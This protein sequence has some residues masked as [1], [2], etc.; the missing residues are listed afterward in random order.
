MVNP[1]YARF[2]GDKLTRKFR[3][4]GHDV[5]GYWDGCRKEYSFLFMDGTNFSFKFSENGKGTVFSIVI[6]PTSEKTGNLEAFVSTYVERDDVFIAQFPR[7]NRRREFS[8]YQQRLRLEGAEIKEDVCRLVY[9]LTTKMPDT[10]EIIH[11]TIDYYVLR[12]ALLFPR[13]KGR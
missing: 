1:S 3:T 2:I 4:Q 11:N 8:K 12:R 6:S 7:K 13:F 5:R 9:R 10:R